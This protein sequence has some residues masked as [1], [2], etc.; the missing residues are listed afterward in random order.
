M[1][2]RGPGGSG[3]F[4]PPGDAQYAP[5]RKAT[6]EGGPAAGEGFVVRFVS[7]ISRFVA[8]VDPGLKPWWIL[9]NRRQLIS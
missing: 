5:R 1:S 6:L 7:F 8:V 4:D 3:G 9:G 2:T